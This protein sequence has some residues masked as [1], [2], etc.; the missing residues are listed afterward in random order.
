MDHVVEVLVEE[1]LAQPL[2]LPRIGGN[3]IDRASADGGVEGL[4][5]SSV[6]RSAYM[7]ETRS[8]SPV[9]VWENSAGA[10]SAA[11]MRS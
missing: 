7:T 4:T 10:V 5:P 9:K 8:P 3:R 2:P 11:M 6:A 1:G